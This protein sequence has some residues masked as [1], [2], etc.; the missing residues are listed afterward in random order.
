M[1]KPPR[2]AELRKQ[3]G[4]T[5]VQLAEIAGLSRSHLAGIETGASPVN[6]YRME[7]IARALGVAV[8]DLLY[9]G[10]QANGIEAELASLLEKMSDRD[11]D[12]V[13]SL[14]RSLGGDR[15]T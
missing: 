15:E 1:M 9:Q 2:I 10:A 7:K 4:L 8:S 6:T 14:A 12:I 11:K 13:L 3:K 5:Q